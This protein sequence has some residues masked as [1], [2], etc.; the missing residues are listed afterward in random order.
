MGDLVIANISKVAQFGAYCK[1]PEYDNLEVFLPIKEVSSGWIKNIR[2]FIHEGQTIVCKVYFFDKEKGTVDIS[3]K[4]V[5]PKETKDK[6]GAYNLEK[7]LAALFQQ[8]V[9][10]SKLED[11]KEALTSK[12]REEFVTFT[13]LTRNA[14]AS[15]PEFENSKLPKKL[16][17]MIV[18]LIE[19]S[20]KKKRFVVSY[21]LKLTT[22]NTEGGATELRNIISTIKSN[23]VAVSYISAPKYHLSAE[24]KDY[25]DAENKIK[26]A[27]DA[28]KAILKR[29]V[30]E[31]EKEK[32]KKEKEDIMATI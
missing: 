6:L 24:G 26:T 21:L 25:A 14:T 1:L 17:E 13:E 11:Q 12:A 3:L 23:G 9:K 27:T 10:M 31:V 15:S 4:K 29:G 16:K 8:A 20:K 5:T 22:Y 28:A 7:R 32:L 2:E 19:V 18:K 30:L